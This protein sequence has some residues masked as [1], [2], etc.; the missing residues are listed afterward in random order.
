MDWICWKCRGWSYDNRLSWG[1]HSARFCLPC[2]ICLMTQSGPK[3]MEWW[4][5]LPFWNGMR[6]TVRCY[7]TQLSLFQ[8]RVTSSERVVKITSHELEILMRF[9]AYICSGNLLFLISLQT[10]DLL[11][12]KYDWTS[13]FRN[14]FR[15]N[16]HKYLLWQTSSSQL[17]HVWCKWSWNRVQSFSNSG[18]IEWTTLV[19][20][21]TKRSHRQQLLHLVRSETRLSLL[22]ILRNYPLLS[23]P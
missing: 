18:S 19:N 22:L 7:G 9:V 16:R 14:V 15:E 1:K 3:S 21:S 11:H 2:L 13:C 10:V 5:F 17:A 4:S 6:L 12:G 8:T 23:V 20:R